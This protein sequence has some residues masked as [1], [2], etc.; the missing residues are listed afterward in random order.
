MIRIVL[1]AMLLVGIVFALREW[2][3]SRVLCLAIASLALAGIYFVWDEAQTTR[4]ANALGVGRG[5][6]LVLYVYAAISF[7]L[8]VSLLL[9]IKQLHEQFTDLARAVALAD[10]RRVEQEAPPGSLEPERGP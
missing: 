9:R 8:I 6:D 2:K 7:V 10:V 3:R 5:A 1:T 4:I